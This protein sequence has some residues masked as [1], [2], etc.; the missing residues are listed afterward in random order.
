M[1]RP[2]LATLVVVLVAVST[3]LFVILDRPDEEPA[4]TGPSLMDREQMLAEYHQLADRYPHPLPDGVRFPATLPAPGQPTVYEVGEGRNQAD[5]F[6]ICAWIGEW[7]A[8]RSEPGNR[9]AIAWSW[10]QRADETQL[11]REHYDD[12]RDVWHQQILG[13]A[14]RGDVRSLREFYSTSCGYEGLRPAGSD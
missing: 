7:L 4:P 5:S 14:G 11:H 13:P 12:P 10:L 6:W 2:S 9:A 3:A 1:P 8:V